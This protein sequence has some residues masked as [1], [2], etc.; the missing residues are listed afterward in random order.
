MWIEWSHLSRAGLAAKEA[1]ERRGGGALVRWGPRFYPG[2]AS[3]EE[4]AVSTQAGPLL[5]GGFW[6]AGRPALAPTR[7]DAWR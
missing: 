7:P 3:S 5:P 4:E 2:D 1:G 6:Q